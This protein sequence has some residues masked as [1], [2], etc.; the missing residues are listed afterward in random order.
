[1]PAESRR[2]LLNV[3][4]TR[5][6]GGRPVPTPTRLMAALAI[7][8]NPW[9]G[10]G[11]VEDLSP[12]IRYHCPEIGRLLAGMILDATGDGI[13]GVGKAS[14]VGMGGETEHALALTHSLWFGNA[15]RAAIGATGHL[16]FANTRAPAGCALMI[17]LMDKDDAGRR[18]HDQTIH[19]TVPDAP[20]DDEIVVALGASVGGHP[21][22][23]IGDRAEDLRAMARDPETPAGG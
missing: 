5:I 14:V 21:W 23:R 20:S 1:M 11:W 7:I 13:E 19:L 3:Q 10:R 16:A 8:R 12:E 22:H 17:P 6:E 15:V 9:F 18:S 4:T 2:T